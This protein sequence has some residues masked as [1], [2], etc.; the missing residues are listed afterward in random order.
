MD[1]FVLWYLLLDVEFKRF[2]EPFSDFALSEFE[3]N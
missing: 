3:V 1:K 2:H